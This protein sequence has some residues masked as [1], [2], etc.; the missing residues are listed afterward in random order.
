MLALFRLNRDRPL[1]C[2]Q[3]SLWLGTEEALNGLCNSQ[4]G[5]GGGGLEEYTWGTVSIG[6]ITLTA[7][8]WVLVS[9]LCEHLLSPN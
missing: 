3:K 5:G 4:G 2:T 9:V 6:R 8:P 1:A 7:G